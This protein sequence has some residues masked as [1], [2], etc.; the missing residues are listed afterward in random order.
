MV[1]RETLKEGKL[2]KTLVLK[3]KGNLPAGSPLTVEFQLNEDGTLYIKGY[4]SSGNTEVEGYVNT[5]ALL[6]EEEIEDQKE[7][8]EEMLL[9][10]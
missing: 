10:V 4:E 8:I 1:T 5:E 6:S 2:I 7:Q 9:I 3:I